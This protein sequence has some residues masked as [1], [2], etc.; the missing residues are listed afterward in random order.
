MIDDF[1][2]RADPRQDPLLGPLLAELDAM[3]NAQQ[4]TLARSSAQRPSVPSQPNLVQPGGSSN[5]SKNAF[6]F[7]LDVFLYCAFR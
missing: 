6:F 1:V 3:S 7:R 4:Q 2:S 5:H